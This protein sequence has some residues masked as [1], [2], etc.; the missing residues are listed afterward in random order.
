MDRIL[1][2]LPRSAAANNEAPGQ[3]QGPEGRFI[4]GAPQQPISV[5]RPSR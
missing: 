1:R 3:V 2:R 5:G 4:G